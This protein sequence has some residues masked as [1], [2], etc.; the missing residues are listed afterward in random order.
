MIKIASIDTVIAKCSAHV[1]ASTA[2]ASSSSQAGGADP[3][4]GWDKVVGGTGLD[5]GMGAHRIAGMPRHADAGFDKYML[6]GKGK[7]A[8]PRRRSARGC[9][10]WRACRTSTSSATARRWTQA[11]GWT[12]RTR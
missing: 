4:A 3:C 10:R 7:L 6:W 5:K 11:G 1:R 8:S 12:W 9:G 2:G